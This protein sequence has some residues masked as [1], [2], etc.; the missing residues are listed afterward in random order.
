MLYEWI[1]GEDS[2]KWELKIAYNKYIK[3]RKS[4]DT[5]WFS[6]WLDYLQ[7]RYRYDTINRC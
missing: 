5:N 6:Y 4:S 2:A 7:L 1:I 3:A